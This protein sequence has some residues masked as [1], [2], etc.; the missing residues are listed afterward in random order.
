MKRLLYAGLVLMVLFVQTSADNYNF[1]LY[2]TPDPE[3]CSS[4]QACVAF[5]QSVLF[6]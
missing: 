6:L 3:L 1:K 5:M 4:D 2:V